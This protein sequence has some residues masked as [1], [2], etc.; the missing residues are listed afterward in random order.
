MNGVNILL[1]YLNRV[2]NLLKC[3]YYYLNLIIIDFEIL[4]ERICIIFFN[5]SI[6]VW[7]FKVYLKEVVGDNIFV[8]IFFFLINLIF[9]LNLKI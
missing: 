3:L 9:I 7:F 5:L 4:F 8:N 2:S 1:S 6:L